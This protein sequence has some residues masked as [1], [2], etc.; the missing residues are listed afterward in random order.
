MSAHSLT[1]EFTA[2][3]Q[4]L[5]SAHVLSASTDGPARRE[6]AALTNE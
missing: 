4:G 3:G 2:G 5:T 1:T 6:R